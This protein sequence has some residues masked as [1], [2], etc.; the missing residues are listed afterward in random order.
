M[1]SL[2]SYA[3]STRSPLLPY[4]HHAMPGTP[5]SNHAVRCAMSGSVI[6][7]ERI[8]YAVCGADTA[9]AASPSEG[10]AGG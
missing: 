5:H 7:T 4:E 1:T 2:S 10:D 8:V 3:L 9:N 6:G